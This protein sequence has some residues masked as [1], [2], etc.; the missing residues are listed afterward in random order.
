MNR[1]T[2]GAPLAWGLAWLLVA[3]G[4]APAGCSRSDDNRKET[5]P[6]TGQVFVDGQ[7]ASQLQVEMHDVKGFDTKQPTVS[8]TYTDDT[9]KFSLSTYEYGDGVPEGEY[10]VAFMWGQVNML[11]KSY[12]GPDK[13]LERYTKEKSPIKVKVEKGKPTDMGKVDLTTK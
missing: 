3:G 11:T 5:Y 1:S 9:G 12:D 13:L 4:L 7:P 10:I 8:I 6:V 2:C